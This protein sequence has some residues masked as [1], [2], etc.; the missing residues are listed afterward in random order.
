MKTLHQTMDIF[1]NNQYIYVKFI[2]VKASRSE[3]QLQV[4]EANIAKKTLT[5]GGL[6]SYIHIQ[7]FGR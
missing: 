6:V 2:Y 1:S 4:N 3:Y 7:I 5:T